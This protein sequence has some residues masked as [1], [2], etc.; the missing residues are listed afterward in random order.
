ME[1]TVTVWGLPP[2]LPPADLRHWHLAHVV[3]G[4]FQRTLPT[5][6]LLCV[7]LQIDIKGERRWFGYG[8]TFLL[9]P[10]PTL[11]L[12]LD[13]VRVYFTVLASARLPN[14]LD[15]KPDTR[16]LK[17]CLRQCS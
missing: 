15:L 1:V 13:K 14:A 11:I 10:M 8:A 3:A 7:I 9:V 12:A 6:L 4:Q 16:H 17:P 5:N 2:Q